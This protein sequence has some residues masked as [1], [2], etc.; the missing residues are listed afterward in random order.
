MNFFFNINIKGSNCSQ[1]S[2]GYYGTT[3]FKQ[4]P[5]CPSGTCDRFTGRCSCPAN[6]TG[7][8]CDRCIDGLA[9]VNGECLLVP[10]VLSVGPSVG[11]Y[12]TIVSLYGSNFYSNGDWLCAFG[13]KN[14][15][16]TFV[17]NS[18]ITCIAPLNSVGSVFSLI[19]YDGATP[20]HQIYSFK[21]FYEGTII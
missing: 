8:L 15:S 13:E 12:G 14:V 16:A 18:K 1:C 2:D 6:R 21:F 17:S 11:S 4:C 20:I 10:V 19:L 5:P 7:P 3:C 9:L